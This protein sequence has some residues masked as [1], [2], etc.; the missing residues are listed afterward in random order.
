MWGSC[1]AL[2][3]F[4][5][6][7]RA[8]CIWL[9]GCFFV[10]IL[11]WYF[12]GAFFLA[13]SQKPAASSQQPAAVWCA[14]RV[15]SEVT[16]TTPGGTERIHTFLVHVLL[17][18]A[19]THSRYRHRF[20]RSTLHCRRSDSESSRCLCKMGEYKTKAKVKATAKAMYKTKTKA[21]AKAKQWIKPKQMQ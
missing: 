3:R 11:F 2:E 13:S 16:I 15:S 20:A 19:C 6:G 14:Q 18:P 12:L 1:E 5:G 21:N 7:I 8:V 10:I 9:L 17:A 4:L